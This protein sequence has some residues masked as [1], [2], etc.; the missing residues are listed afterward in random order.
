MRTIII[1]SFGLFISCGQ[2]STG[3]NKINRD[4]ENYLNAGQHQAEILELKKS[5]DV[6]GE[7]TTSTTETITINYKDNKITFQSNG[8]LAILNKIT[9]DLNESIV[10]IEKYRLDK[11]DTL[12]VTDDKNGFKSPWKGYRWHF[13]ANK[14]KDQP[15]SNFKPISVTIGKMERN[16]KT[17]VRVHTVDFTDIGPINSQIQFEL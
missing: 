8:Q 1:L 5:D 2:R 15:D 6:I 3:E 11:V 16:K 17:Y 14:D 4:I 13:D 12:N 9:F 10:V 7:F